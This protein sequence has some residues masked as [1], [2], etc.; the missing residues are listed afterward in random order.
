MPAQTTPFQPE[1]L[2]ENRSGVLTA[3]QASQFG[4]MVSARR[5]GTRGLAVPFA[6]I[7]ALLLV[8]SGPAPTAAERYLVGWGFVAAAALLLAAPM[9]DPLAADV[10]GRRVETVQGAIGKR[11]VRST[12]ATGHT[13][14]YLNVAGR[15]LRTFLSAYEAAPDAGYVRAYYLP[16]T[17]RLVNLE[18]LPNPPLPAS[19]DEARDMVGRIAR[20]L[21][22]GDPVASAEA[23]ASAAG[24]IDAAHDLITE[25][26]NSPSRSAAGGLVRGAL[27]GRWTHPLVTVTLAE[28]GMAT[29][30]TIAGASQAGH[31]SVDSQGRLLT[32]VTGTLEPTDAALD[33]DR[34]TIQ[35]EGRRLTFTRA[36]HA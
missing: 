8:L 10:R 6:A 36:A 28:D 23:R 19:A 4:R 15:Q 21:V 34:L 9:F 7:G 14:H 32:D 35:L 3:E 12:A 2:A 18:R 5:K 16:R 22:G 11:R 29:V 33:G 17:R 13:R 30:T 20:A 25:P 24:L 1:A 27:V 26:S 31:W